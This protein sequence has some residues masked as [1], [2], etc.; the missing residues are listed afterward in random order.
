MNDGTERR[1]IDVRASILA[2]GA[3][4]GEALRRRLAARGV[5]AVDVMGSPGSGKT[6][7]IEALA[8]ALGAR[9]RLAVIEADLESRVDTDRLE[10]SGIR[11]VQLRTGGFCHLDAAM[12]ESGL[13]ALGLGADSRGAAPL[14]LVLVENVGNLICTAQAD[15]GA[16][17]NLALLSV[18]EG[19]DKPLKYPVMFAAADFVAVSKADWLGREPFDL[20]A[21][22]A[23]V[24][25]L[26]PA[27]PV[28]AVSARAG[29][30]ITEL[31]AWIE[32]RRGRLVRGDWKGPGRRR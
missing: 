24:R 19:D 17:A 15:C 2:E 11:A 26:N 7:L 23:R 10:A 28:H 13:E 18:P 25:V 22:R 14:D 20:E 4:E 3:R 21:F 9:L 1:I 30:G 12:L 29:T 31:A 5:L 16:H 32:E 6:M 8:A 27:A